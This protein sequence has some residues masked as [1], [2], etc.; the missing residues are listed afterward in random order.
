MLHIRDETLAE[1]GDAAPAFTIDEVVDNPTH[2]DGEPRVGL[3]RT[4]TGTF[5]VPNWLTG[6]GSPGNGFNYPPTHDPDAAP[7]VERQPSRR[8][9]SATSPSR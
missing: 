7:A 4:V 2:D 3:A 8:R 6:D 1:L 5:T 9:S